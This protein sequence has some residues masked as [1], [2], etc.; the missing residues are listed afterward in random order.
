MW[1]LMVSLQA[2]GFCFFA[3]NGGFVVPM[4]WEIM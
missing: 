1:F 3:I 2:Q 4:V